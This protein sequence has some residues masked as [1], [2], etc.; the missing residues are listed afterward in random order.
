MP[1]STQR[2][3]LTESQLRLVLPADPHYVRVART[4]ARGLGERL[5]M[6]HRDIEDLSLAVDE[7]L[8]LLLRP[9]GA[10]E[11]AEVIFLFTV[12]GDSLV[13]DAGSGRGTEPD[14]ASLS[15]FDALVRPVVDELEVRPGD[16]SV[17]FTKHL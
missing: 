6:R 7:T 2:Q 1:S 8:V 16:P 9:E 10:A 17:H 4:A 14:P 11:A 15:R 13:V 3:N 12:E 5:G